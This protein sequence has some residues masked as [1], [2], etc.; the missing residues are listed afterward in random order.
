MNEPD[1]GAESWDVDGISLFR[2]LGYVVG[3]PSFIVGTALFMLGFSLLNATVLNAACVLY[4]LAIVA[5]CGRAVLARL[6]PRN[7]K[8]ALLIKINALITSL[9]SNTEPWMKL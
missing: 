7:E 3:L 2:A 9:L 6:Q 1:R 4:S 8:Q 5:I